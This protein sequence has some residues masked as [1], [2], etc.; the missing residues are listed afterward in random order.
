[1]N[2][3]IKNQVLV[4]LN[5]AKATL[6][7][8]KSLTNMIENYKLDLEKDIEV[9]ELIH[10]RQKDVTLEKI[11]DSL[12]EIL[13]YDLK[14]KPKEDPKKDEVVNFAPKKKRE[15]DKTGRILRT[16]TVDWALVKKMVYDFLIKGAR[17]VT[18]GFIVA[19]IMEYSE[20]YANQKRSVSNAVTS[21][22][23]TL[24]FVSKLDKGI[25]VHN[26]NIPPTVEQRGVP[27]PWEKSPY[28]VEKKEIQNSA[29]T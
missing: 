28:F 9:L 21:A 7:S 17:P 2:T 10:K 20:D 25:Y 19:H 12:A 11:N 24:P 1:M 22:L 18:Y 15:R 16:G 8:V 5:K 26:S 13:I 23:K 3:D 27:Q 6:T 29:G 14:A 4:E